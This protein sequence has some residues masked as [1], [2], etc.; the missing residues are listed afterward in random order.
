MIVN[1]D[2]EQIKKALHDFHIST[3][4]AIDLLKEDFSPVVQNRLAFNEY[5]SCIQSTKIGKAA[6]KMSDEILLM[7]CRTSRKT[8]MHF[9]QAGLI[10]AASPIFYDDEIV[11]YI[12]FGQIRGD[13]EFSVLRDYIAELGLD[14]HL[15]ENLYKENVFCDFGKVECLCNVA[16][17]LIN[18]IL[19]KNMLK[20]NV[21]KSLQA[22]LSYIDNNFTNELSILSISKATG[23]SKSALY[24]KFH[25]SLGCTV[26]EY[27]NKKRVKY[28]A[29][30]IQNT[31]LSMETI[32][33]KAGFSNVS[34]FSRTFKKLRGI[35]PITFKKS[36]RS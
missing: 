31:D 16:A 14:Q 30:L 36:C 7:R 26:S 29:S 15:M 19:F 22:A 4:V 3:G 2:I 8:E 5:C 33:H 10:D 34:Y 32:A 27:I 6:C 17:M 23:I 13:L 25:T 1:Y 28:A 18:H 24:K 11:G 9:C 20:P 21:D 35:P 12:I